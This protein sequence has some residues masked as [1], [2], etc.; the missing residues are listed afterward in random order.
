MRAKTFD[1]QSSKIE[2]FGP[3]T[4]LA[5]GS[6][7]QLEDALYQSYGKGQI[8]KDRTILMNKGGSSASPLREGV[9]F[10]YGK[11]LDASTSE[12]PTDG[13]GDVAGGIIDTGVS[14]ALSKPLRILNG[15]KNIKD[16]TGLNLKIFAYNLSVIASPPPPSDRIYV[17]PLTGKFVLP[18]PIYWSKCESWDNITNPEL[19]D[20]TSYYNN[21]GFSVGVAAG[22]FGNSIFAGLSNVGTAKLFLSTSLSLNKFTL[23]FWQ[24][25]GGNF[26]YFEVYHGKLRIE[27]WDLSGVTRAYR[28]KWDN[29]IV[30]TGTY[31]PSNQDKFHAYLVWDE[32]GGLSGGKCLRYFQDGVESFYLEGSY[33]NI[34]DSF[35]LGIGSASKDWGTTGIDNIKLWDH[36]VSE[37]PSFEYNGGTGREDAMHPIYGATDGYKPNIIKAGFFYKGDSTLPATLPKPVGE[38]EQITLEDISDYSNGVG[39]FGVGRRIYDT[40]YSVLMEGE[41]FYYDEAW[42]GTGTHAIDKYDDGVSGALAIGKAIRIVHNLDGV[43][44]NLTTMGL[45]PIVK[46]MVTDNYFPPANQF[47]IDPVRGKIILPRPIYW[48]KLESS[49]NITTPNIGTDSVITDGDSFTAGKFNNCLFLDAT[50]GITLKYHRS[51]IKNENL[52]RGSASFWG[53]LTYSKSGSSSTIYGASVGI[54]GY[55]TAG[56]AKNG[57]IY[58]IR[59]HGSWNGWGVAL[60]SRSYDPNSGVHEVMLV[61]MY[62]STVIASTTIALATIYHVYV[63]WNQSGL[64]S[65]NNIEVYLNGTLTLFSNTTLPNLDS[66]GYTLQS[67]R[68]ASTYTFYNSAHLDNIKIWDEVHTSPDFEYNSNNGRES[69]LHPIYGS[70]SGYEPILISPGGVG[71]NK[72]SGV[73]SLVRGTI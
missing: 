4:G 19:G 11:R 6:E 56:Y 57:S 66:F 46:E 25:T 47:Y 59:N 12:D 58:H 26:D 41:D 23:S 65:G 61:L 69:A 54:G 13:F 16:V 64:L 14:G 51:V 73:G 2:Y 71:Y 29:I 1:K 36:V 24:T 27:C 28:I 34:A 49:L 44:T 72:A 35:Y 60:S 18:R 8:G 42:D 45:V 52:S 33:L 43:A 10:A 67:F 48:N 38:D 30:K 3:W 31:T 62:G 5:G 70:Q 39:Y 22:K 68:Y 17:D 21:A 7:V 20:G 55:R 50:T 9:D 53:R 40:D 32:T 15:D 63:I 37:D